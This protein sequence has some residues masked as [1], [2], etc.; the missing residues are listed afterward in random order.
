[1]TNCPKCQTEGCYI[2]FIGNVECLNSKCIHYSS[3]LTGKKSNQKP[4]LINTKVSRDD[5]RQTGRTTRQI[6]SCISMAVDDQVVFFV[7][8]NANMRDYA[9]ALVKNNTDLIESYTN[10]KFS[11]KGSKGCL[12]ILTHN[13]YIRTNFLVG[14]PY[15]FR[16]VIFDHAC[17]YLIKRR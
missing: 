9:A 3:D 7:V 12:T 16:Q 15:D 4:A 6:E 8:H 1:M 5:L 10:N 14:F 17:E 11:F 2:S 13:E